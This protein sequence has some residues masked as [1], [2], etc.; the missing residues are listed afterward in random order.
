MT[1]G[2]LHCS[3]VCSLHQA[4]Q[5][6]VL[7]NSGY[8]SMTNHRQPIGWFRQTLWFYRHYQPAQRRGAYRV[9]LFGRGR[10][11]VGYGALQLDSG[12]LLVTECVAADCRG[13]GIGSAILQ[14]MIAI[15]STE[16]RELVA[17]ISTS[18][19]ASIRLHERA[20]LE[21]RSSVQQGGQE[22]RHYSRLPNTVPG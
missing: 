11:P 18:N 21:L 22:L 9:F 8:Q 16:Q 6:R 20:G 7:R 19:Q 14:R 2:E 10:L 3:P 1:G 12:R 4:Q 13:Q 15:A 5:V 17:E